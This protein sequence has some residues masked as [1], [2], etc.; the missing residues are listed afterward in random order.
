VNLTKFDDIMLGFITASV[1][2]QIGQTVYNI[3]MIPVFAATVAGWSIP[4]LIWSVL[5]K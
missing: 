4:L 3:S 5:E 1:V 2:S